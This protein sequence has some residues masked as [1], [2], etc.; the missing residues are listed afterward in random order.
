MFHLK[1]TKEKWELVSEIKSL[2]T[3]LDY[4]LL[5]CSPHFESIVLKSAEV[6]VFRM[7]HL[8]PEDSFKMHSEV[9]YPQ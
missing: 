5:Y 2:N 1:I 3:I 4:F 8:L 7:G 9:A 6:I